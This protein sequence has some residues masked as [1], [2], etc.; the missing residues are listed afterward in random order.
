MENEEHSHI[1]L[2]RTTIVLDC[3]RQITKNND[4]SLH[5]FRAPIGQPGL[6]PGASFQD[7]T[8]EGVFTT[9]F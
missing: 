9:N 7:A 2:Q 1:S 3:K 6:P 4:F 5:F 8:L